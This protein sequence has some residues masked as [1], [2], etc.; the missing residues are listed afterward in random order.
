MARRD[1][2]RHLKRRAG[3]ALRIGPFIVRI[4]SPIEGVCAGMR[5]M[6]PDYPLASDEPFA[7][8]H[9]RL[10]PAPGLRRW[11]RPQVIFKLDQLMPFKPLP[12]VQAYPLF[13]WSLNWCVANHAHE[14][15][16]LHAAV[17]ERGGLA[18]ILPGAPGSGKSTVCAALI[19][20]GWRLLSDELALISRR[21]GLVV[22]LPRPV[23]LK[24]ESIGLI[25]RFCPDATIGPES[26]DT[27]KGTVAH[28]K[29]PAESV[30]RC[31]LPA[32]PAWIILPRYEP[33][34]GA[35]LE[36]LP[37]A[38]GF[39]RVAE[40]SF[41]YSVL[42]LEGFQVLARLLDQC[43]CYTLQHSDLDR[44]VDVIGSLPPPL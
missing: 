16:I 20:R 26:H 6:Y 23:S 32:R 28:M 14:Y 40:S 33:G 41:N 12:L 43:A 24:N 31:V 13:E 5:L 22:P 9:L 1:L 36:P 35:R 7:D 42:G 10:L 37:K 30:R 38:R 29:A 2:R 25:H 39:L 11:L 44:T 4:S 27:A 34:A 17:V 21:S 19:S 18:A 15:L 8:F 3:L